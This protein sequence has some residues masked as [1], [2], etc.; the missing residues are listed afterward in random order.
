MGYDLS[1]H[2]IHP[3][4]S[5]MFSSAPSRCSLARESFLFQHSCPMSLAPSVWRSALIQPLDLFFD[6]DRCCILDGWCLCPLSA[7][8]TLD[9]GCILVLTSEVMRLTFL[10]LRSGLP[11]LFSVKESDSGHED[12]LVLAGRLLILCQRLLVV[13]LS[14]SLQLATEAVMRFLLQ[15]REASSRLDS[16]ASIQQRRCSSRYREDSRWRLRRRICR[17]CWSGLSTISSHSSPSLFCSEV[18]S[19]ADTRSCTSSSIMVLN[20]ET[21]HISTAKTS[22][23]PYRGHCQI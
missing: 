21:T 12:C 11:G 2:L 19:S 15:P 4:P 14:E 9:F 20:K 6:P 18:C 13:R 1:V 10:L 8:E 5:D 7:L 17:R 3:Y 22:L 23:K 16:E